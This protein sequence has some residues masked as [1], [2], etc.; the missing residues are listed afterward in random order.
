MINKISKIPPIK[1]TSQ[2]ITGNLIGL[3]NWVCKDN[4]TSISK[5]FNFKNFEDTWSFLTKISMRSHLIGH[6]PTIVNTYNKVNLKLTT[7]DCN[8]LSDIDFKMAKKFDDYYK[9]YE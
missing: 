3:R 4:N 6:H 8:G 2:Q 7:H 1:L 9:N 5:D